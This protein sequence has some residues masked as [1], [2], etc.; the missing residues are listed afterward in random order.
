MQKTVSFFKHFGYM[1][2]IITLHDSRIEK[3]RENLLQLFNS[4]STHEKTN[5]LHHKATGGTGFYG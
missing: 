4:V 5:Y 2:N 3:T 1:D